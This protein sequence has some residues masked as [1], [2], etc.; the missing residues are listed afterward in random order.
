MR[1]SVPYT[2]AHTRV[3]ARAQNL[4]ELISTIDELVTNRKA[5]LERVERLNNRL[6]INLLDKINATAHKVWVVSARVYTL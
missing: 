6:D 1:A 2:H 4:G 3:C 5:M